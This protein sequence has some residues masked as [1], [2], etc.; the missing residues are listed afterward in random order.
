[1]GFRIRAAEPSDLAVI[2]DFNLRL[3]MET[4]NKSLDSNVLSQ[5]VEAAILD[6]SKIEY[7]V[8]V[9]EFTGAVIG[10]IGLTKEWSDW[11]NG[12]IWWFQSVYVQEGFRGKGAFRALNDH[13]RVRARASHNVIGLRLYVEEE[14]LRA[15]STYCALG[16]VDGGYNVLEDLWKRT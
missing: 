6:P 10:Q 1:M 2:V 5:G 13:V 4:E 7:W 8:A 3:A 16:F 15:K 11:R 12:W 14:N 9:D